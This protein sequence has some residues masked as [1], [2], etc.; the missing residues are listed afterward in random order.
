[1]T[2]LLS[3]AAAVL[4]AVAFVPS[5]FAETLVYPTPKDAMFKID[6]PKGWSGEPAEEEGGFMN[7]EGPTGVLISVRTVQ[8]S[9]YT[10]DDVVT[11]GREF[12][13]ENY[14]RVEWLPVK[15]EPASWLLAGS[16]DNDGTTV[17]FSHVMMPGKEVIF[18]ARLVADLDDDVGVKQGTAVLETIRSAE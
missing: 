4:L 13:E 7:L 14:T 11:E 9:E 2:S 10:L 18:E 15:K 17:V 1:M 5:A 16:G 12:I 6:I 8:A 3:R